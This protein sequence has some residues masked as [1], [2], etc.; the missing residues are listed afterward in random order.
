[1]DERQRQILVRSTEDWDISPYLLE[2]GCLD[3]DRIPP[4][5]EAR[6][7]L[8]RYCWAAE[9]F[10]EMRVLDYGCGVGYGS[11]I[12][13]DV[14]HNHVTS[15]DTSGAACERAVARGLYVIVHNSASEFN[16]GFFDGVVAFEV[17]EHLVDPQHFI[18][19]LPARHLVASVPVEPTV[20][21]NPNHQHDFTV[22][23][24]IKMVEGPM[25]IHSWWTQTRPHHRDPSYIVLHAEVRNGEAH[26]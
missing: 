17:L 9:V 14:G 13:R 4:C 26:G 24:F 20:G 8:E 21:R 5:W 12:L 6:A 25:F 22:D 15:V 11:E 19:N 3:M 1:M 10:R 2:G 16:R 23:G 18:D 7:H